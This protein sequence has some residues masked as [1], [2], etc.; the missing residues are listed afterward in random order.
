M[1]SRPLGWRGDSPGHGIQFRASVGPVG[2]KENLS[3]VPDDHGLGDDSSRHGAAARDSLA[4]A[5]RR[6]RQRYNRIA[7]VYDAFEGVMEGLA[8]QRWRRIAWDRV[9]GDSILEV[10]VGTGKNIPFQP[11]DRQ[12]VAI[13]LSGRMLARALRKEWSGRRLH[14]AQMD[15]QALGIPDASVDTVVATF[16]FCSVPDPILGLREA[17][18]VL[19]PGGRLVLLEHVLS[20]LPVLRQL[21]RLLNPIV[22]TVTGANIDRDTVGNVRR[23]GFELEELWDFGVGGIFKLIVARKPGA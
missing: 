18:R 7:D 12:V 13:D 3:G 17:R 19:K 23:I 1:A 22:V 14:L 8:Y 4:R 2:V 9:E 20:P 21:M 15:V 10:G 6:A 11:P 16:V 5:A